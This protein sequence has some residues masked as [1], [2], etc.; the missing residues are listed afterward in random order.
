MTPTIPAHVPDKPPL[1]YADSFD[2]PVLFRNGPAAYENYEDRVSVIKYAAEMD[3]VAD[4]KSVY[5]I[6]HYPSGR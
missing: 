2:I 3:G 6:W 4:A 5:D 1:T